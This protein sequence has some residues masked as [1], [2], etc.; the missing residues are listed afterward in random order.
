MCGGN[1]DAIQLETPKVPLHSSLLQ[2]QIEQNSIPFVSEARGD[3]NLVTHFSLI[4]F[5]EDYDMGD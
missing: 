2:Q 4:S 1:V 3:K 5:Y